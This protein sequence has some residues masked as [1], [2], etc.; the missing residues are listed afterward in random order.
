[1]KKI[2]FDVEKVR[3]IITKSS[4]GD[5]PKWFYK[6][7]WYKRDSLGYEGL[8]EVVISRLLDRK[9][10]NN[11]LKY[12][13]INILYDGKERAGCYSENFLD[14]KEELITL[15]R[16]HLSYTGIGL[17]EKLE[18]IKT[19]EERIKYT[20]DFIEKNTGLTYFHEWMTSIIYL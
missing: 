5:Q 4:K 6:N 18:Q 8:S 10:I 14:E 7:Q 2:S 19:T 20:V 1:M 17:G 13:P 3:P 9:N 12:Y 16:F 11:I 15:E